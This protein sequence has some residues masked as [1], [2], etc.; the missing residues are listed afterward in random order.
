VP[1][2]AGTGSPARASRLVVILDVNVYLDAARVV[3]APFTWERLEAAGV[4]ARA[5]GVP[6][7]RDPG[8]DSVLTILAC[9]G[10]Q[11]ADGR[12]LSV[13]TSDHINLMVASKAAHP[14]SGVG[15]PGLGWLDADAQTLLE[16]LVWEVVIR[17]EGNTVG[18]I[19]SA[20]GD[21]P[22]DH[23]DGT[24]YATA[25]DADDPDDG[26]VDRVCI[27]RD[28]GFLNASLPGLI[29]VVSP[30]TWILEYQAEERKRAMRRLSAARP[31]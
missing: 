22:L 14:T 3:G 31:R 25:R 19:V 9:A 23:E 17:S 30:S 29:Q 11:H 7:R 2:D 15:N 10:G 13:W 5:D 20:Y 18:E 28:T 4:R 1:T 26:Y 12:S 16:D 27:T 24:V 6:H 8:L 21:P